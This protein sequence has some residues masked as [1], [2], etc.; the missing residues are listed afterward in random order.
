MFDPNNRVNP[1][2]SL[3]RHAQVQKLLRDMVTSGK[4]KPGDKIPAEVD[5]ADSLGVSKMTVNKALL[6]L[7][8]DGLFVREVGRGTFVASPVS[9]PSSTQTERPRLVLSFVEGAKNV[10]DSD[11]YGTIY[12]GVADAVQNEGTRDPAR[13]VRLDLAPLAAQD[14]QT[15]NERDPADGRLV[16][17][18]RVQSVP[19]LE[20][21]WQ[22]GQSLVVVGASWPMMRVPSVD[23]DNTG[24]AMEAVRHLIGLGHTRIALLFAEEETANT[25]D[26]ITGYRRALTLAGLPQNPDLEIRSDAAWRI[27]DTARQRLS[28][29]LRG[30]QPVTALFAA[31]HYLSLE[32]KNVAREAGLR[33]PD[34]VSVVGYDDPISAQ[35]VYPPLTTVRQPLYDMGRRA[36]ERLMRLVWG[37]DKRESI[38]EMLPTRLIVRQST[39]SCKHG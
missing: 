14:Y 26:R 1:H 15:E 38:R 33:V 8:A 21:L 23:S 5:I 28:A 27:G 31:G 19:S 7:T 34:D 39:T 11:Y 22:A 37:E 16:I 18:P 2:D 4:L 25:Q 17:A 12:R 9:L 36:A 24:G 35:L 3:P 32:A 10:L 30:P 29:L 6:A 13:R 20:A